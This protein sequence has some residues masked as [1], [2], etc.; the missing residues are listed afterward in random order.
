MTNPRPTVEATGFQDHV[1]LG[2][3]SLDKNRNY[4]KE[5]QNRKFFVDPGRRPNLDLLQGHDEFV[6]RDRGEGETEVKSL[7]GLLRWIGDH[8]NDLQ[9]NGIITEDMDGSRRLAVDFV[10]RRG[11]LHDLF[12]SAHLNDRSEFL[13]TLYRGTYYLEQIELR[14]Q[15]DNPRDPDGI[16]VYSGKKFAQYCTSSDG[17]KP[18][19]SVPIDDNVSYEAVVA[20]RC[21]DVRLLFS[22]EIH[23]EIKE[24]S[25]SPPEVR[26]P[27]HLNYVNIRTTREFNGLTD[28][29]QSKAFF[30]KKLFQFWSQNHIAGIPR[31]ILGW[32]DDKR[33]V[34]TRVESYQT[35]DIPGIPLCHWKPARYYNIMRTLLAE[36][37]SH[38]T[39]DDPTVVYHLVLERESEPLPYHELAERLRQRRFKIES[40]T[41]HIIVKDW[42]ISQVLK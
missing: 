33:H 3:F 29:Q 5:P 41:D 30:R 28:I 9:R 13:V 14:S 25:C 19:T 22:V 23:A 31:V 16:Q 39:T 32:R 26:P 15:R 4:C 34:I 35:E 36:I 24:E 6:N 12:K 40:R 27:H 42:F 18:D 20:A 10:S 7:D 2:N 38:V 8:V 37:T 21:D 1:H 11:A 17:G